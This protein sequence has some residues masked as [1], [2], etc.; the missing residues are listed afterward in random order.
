MTFDPFTAPLSAVHVGF[1]GNR[2][3]RDD[4]IRRDPETLW[5]MTMDPTARWLVLDDL[6]P[7]ARATADSVELAWVRRSEAPRGDTVFLG[8]DAEGTPRFAVAGSAAG[9]DGE[10]MDARALATR[11]SGDQAGLVAQARS[12]V[13]WHLRHGFCAACGGQTKLDKGG[14]ERDC[15]AC[16]AEHFPRTDP[17]AIMLSIDV[18]NDRCL[19]G[20]QPRFPKGFL[21]ALAGFVEPGES[22]EEAVARE[23]YE[24]AGVRTGRVRYVASQPWPFPSSLMM[25]AFAEATST[26]IRIDETE[27]EEV[28]WMSRDDVRSALAGQGPFAAPPPLAI[29]HTLLKAW[30]DL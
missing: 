27:L 19:L 3:D 9:L 5:A 20:R 29:A 14:Y 25:G 8:V 6:R 7:L 23:L 16:G 13:D 26:D 30:I 24:E 15:T 22:F 10:P 4:R 21:S 2:I 11:L 12:L 18:A 28:V 17:V 1:T